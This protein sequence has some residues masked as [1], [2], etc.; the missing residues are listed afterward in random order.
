MK[1]K[2]Y[3]TLTRKKETFVPLMEDSAYHW[4]AKDFVWIYSCWPTVYSMPHFGNLRAWFTADL[5]RNTIKYILWYKTIMVSNF[6]DVW[7][8]VWDWDIWED[9]LEKWSRLE[10]LSA[11]DVAKKYENIFRD[12]FKWLNISDFDYTPRATESIDDQIK[13]IQKIESKWYTYIVPWDWIYMDTSKIP[14]YGKLLWAN[15]KKALEWIQAGERIDMWWKEN[16]TDFALW[17]FS[18]TDEKRQ[19]ERDSPRWIWFPG[20]HSECC[21]MSSNILWNQFD[22]HHGWVDLIP[23]HHTNEIAQSELVFWVGPRVKYRM[24]NEFVLMN[25][26]K[27][28]KSEWNSV[29]PQDVIDKWYDY[30]DVRFFFFTTNYRTFFDFTRDS[31]QQA[32]NTRK[33]LIK[34]LSKF[35]TNNIFDNIQSFNQI[36]TQLTSVLW[37]DFW[38]EIMEAICDDLNTP[39]V[40]SIINSYL[41]EPNEEVIAIIHWLEKKFLKV[42]LFDIIVEEKIDIPSEIT[43]LAEQRIQAKKDKNFLLADELRNKIQD[44]G[45]KIKDT[46][47]WFEIIYWDTKKT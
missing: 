47:D 32:Q 13:F 20:W 9:K 40:L 24:H 34:K 36:E 45:Y 16:P 41:S 5:I 11:R 3:N 38:T 2:I 25:G 39:Q 33:N 44:A 21:V 27:M 4:P 30:L 7:H 23:I 12:L 29:S 14:D 6:T 18:P 35:K 46:P 19:M 1:L 15:Y 26:K 8:L 43:A 31:M 37:K 10:W 28:W 42:W 22:I 17:K